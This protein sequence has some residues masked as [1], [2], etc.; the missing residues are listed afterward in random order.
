MKNHKHDGE[1]IPVIAPY[2]VKSGEGCK[3]GALFGVASTDTLAGQ[4][5]QLRR[6]GVFDLVKTSAQAWTQGAKIYWDDANKRCTTATSGN[7][8]IGAASV[9]AADPSDTSLV[10]LDGVVR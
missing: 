3:V 9:A 2:D 5:V 10:L 1:V 7:S 8:V 6:R 4:L